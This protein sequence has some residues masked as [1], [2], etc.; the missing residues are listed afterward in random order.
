MYRH[1]V[2]DLKNRFTKYAAV[3]FAAAAIENVL[4]EQNSFGDLH[5]RIELMLDEVWRLPAHPRVQGKSNMTE[6]EARALPSAR[7]YGHTPA[8]LESCAELEGERDA[9]QKAYHLAYGAFANLLFM[10]WLLDGMERFLNPG[11]PLVVGSDIS[12]TNWTA[13]ADGLER[14]AKAARDPDRAFEWQKHVIRRLSKEQPYAPDAFI[15]TP[16]DKSYFGITRLEREPVSVPDTIPALADGFQH[17]LRLDEVEERLTEYAA[18]ALATGIIERLVAVAQETPGVKSFLSALVDDLWSWQASPK[19]EGS[20]NM[21]EEEAEALPSHQFYRRIDELRELAQTYREL[22][23]IRALLDATRSALGFIAWMMDGIEGRM[24]PGKPFVLDEEL[25]D[26]G[27]SLL[28]DAFEQT[29]AASANPDAMLT[30]ERQALQR[31]R[32]QQPGEAGKQTLGEPVTRDAF[33]RIV[34]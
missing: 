21:S 13:L 2:E 15:G 6:Q 1:A 25:D 10:V 19:P 4:G 30:W 23:A 27:W 31:L 20:E 26:K 18:I 33:Q 22:S 5:A 8:L 29:V 12:D 24:N 16:L 17:R 9:Q 28:L 3:G 11:K 7:L 32:Q 14:L 34:R